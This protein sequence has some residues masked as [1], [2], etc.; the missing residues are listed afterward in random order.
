MSGYPTK[1]D[2]TF[3]R[4]TNQLFWSEID[5]KWFKAQGIAESSINPL[6]I[7][8]AGSRGIMQIMPATFDEIRD[9]LNLP[10]DP[11]NYVISIK[12]GT[13]YN[14]RLYRVWKAEKGIERSR[15]TFASYNAGLANI[16]KA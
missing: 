7:S 5:W 2:A 1:Y 3:Q 13:Y 10:N 4:F 6:A 11:F 12:A 14:K 15:F 9:T 16:L 8:P